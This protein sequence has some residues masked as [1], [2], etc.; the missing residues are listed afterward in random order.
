M[1]LIAA[2]TVLG[3]ALA[4]FT[5]AVLGVEL[6]DVLGL[7]KSH[8]FASACGALAATAAMGLNLWNGRKDRRVRDLTDLAVT[9]R[10]VIEGQGATIRAQGATIR[11]QG[12]A[13]DREHTARL[14]IEAELAQVSEQLLQQGNILAAYSGEREPIR[15]LVP[16]DSVDVLVLDDAAWVVESLARL[17]R[18]HGFRVDT[19]LSIADART[20]VAGRNRIGRRYDFAVVD[21]VLPDGSIEDVLDLTCAIHPGTD[22]IVTTGIS[23]EAVLDRAKACATKVLVKPVDLYE[24][25][26]LLGCNV[27]GRKP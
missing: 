27:P 14:V 10:E 16:P 17:F 7:L 18:R 25:L 12:E 23:D 6:A 13:I 15:P 21:L 2:R 4:G 8:N 26:A 19:A 5:L 9:N 3:K 22:V 20:L 11:A 1:T 24:L